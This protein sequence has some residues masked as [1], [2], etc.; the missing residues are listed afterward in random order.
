MKKKLKQH[1]LYIKRCLDLAQLGRGAVAP[2][3]VVG[4]VIVHEHRILGEGY[5]EKVGGPH[6]EIEAI[7][8]V[9]DTSLLNEATIYVSLEPC[10][11]YGRT[12][13]CV[14]SL[15]SYGFKEVV[16]CLVDPDNRV[17]G[18]SIQKL[19]ENGV[20][21]EMG[22]LE[23]EGRRQN[24]F[25]ICKIQRK[26]PYIVLKFAQTKDQVF[27]Y[28]GQQVWISNPYAKRLTHRWRSEIGAI[29]VG[30]NTV[31]ADNPKL[32]NRLYFGNS[33]LRVV[34]DRTLKIS[35][36]TNIYRMDQPTLL[37]TESTL[38]EEVPPSLEIITLPFDDRLLITIL[39]LLY[40]RGID[41]L[42]VEG[43]VYTLQQFI[44]QNLWDEARIFTGGNPDIPISSTPIFAP[45]LPVSS[46]EKYQL[47][48][49]YL[50]VFYNSH[51]VIAD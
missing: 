37:I 18:K 36:T 47:D 44:D 3:P 15:L 19:E 21:V 12:P 42:L 33:P 29:L 51:G 28:Q 16:I 20:A 50:E 39:E 11:H 24:Q 27:G 13:P 31:L 9:H 41:S 48:N 23:K 22:Y 40:Q 45:R 10:F 32:D 17:K 34:L 8:N 30:T 2:N 6:A 49:N 4:A 26:R 7:R 1:N 43:G 46:T 25:F 38:E 35:K 5:H 14:D